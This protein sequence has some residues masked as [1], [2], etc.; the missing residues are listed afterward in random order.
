MLISISTWT[1][2]QCYLNLTL[3]LVWSVLLITCYYDFPTRM[4]YNLQFKAE[5][6]SSP[7]VVFMRVYY[8]ASENKTKPT[9]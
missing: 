5:I 2:V 3:D 1:L 7:Q 9:G 8:T 6:S 4:D